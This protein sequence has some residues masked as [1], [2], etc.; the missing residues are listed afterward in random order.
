MKIVLTG[1]KC[2]GKS[3]LGRLLAESAFLPFFETDLMIEELFKSKNC[4]S[5]SCRAIC[6]QYGEDFFRNIE[7]EVIENVA[8]LDSCVI[9]TGGSTMLNKDSRQLLRLDCVLVLITASIESLFERL[10][11]KEI[12][13]FLNNKTA[14]D[15]FA[16]RASLVNEVIRPYADIV[17]DSSFLA[18]DETFDK[19]VKEIVTL[20]LDSSLEKREKVKF[21]GSDRENSFVFGISGDGK[22]II[23]PFCV[24]VLLKD[25]FAL[26][27]TV[28]SEHPFLVTVKLNTLL[29]AVEED[30]HALQIVLIKKA[31]LMALSGKTTFKKSHDTPID[32]LNVLINS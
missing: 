31:I 23:D 12:P 22:K 11:Q 10:S 29:L 17:I 5:L 6:A 14:K 24:E 16:V 20:L 18:F 28:S 7:R 32:M 9:S 26:S 13:S 1:P 19:L 25:Q 2:S 4:S 21:L 3:K 30:A 15:L 27:A 8:K